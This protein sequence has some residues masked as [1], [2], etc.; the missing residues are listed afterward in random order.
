MSESDLMKL[1]VETVA[2][3]EVLLAV[4][5]Y[6]AEQGSKVQFLSPDLHKQIHDVTMK[7]RKVVHDYV[8]RNQKV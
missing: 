8:E 2:P 3:L 6:A 1:L 4:E 5:T 7:V